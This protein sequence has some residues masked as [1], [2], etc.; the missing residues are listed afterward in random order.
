MKSIYSA[1]RTVRL[2]KHA[3]SPQDGRTIHIQDLRFDCRFNPKMLQGN[4]VLSLHQ[5]GP[6]SEISCSLDRP[7]EGAGAHASKHLFPLAQ[8]TDPND[9]RAVEM[10][11]GDYLY[12]FFLPVPQEDLEAYTK[13]LSLSLSLYLSLCVCARVNHLFCCLYKAALC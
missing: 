5:P 12:P 10:P 9:Y 8:A 11:V 2:A 13:Y 6:V 1:L 4:V 7:E 3:L